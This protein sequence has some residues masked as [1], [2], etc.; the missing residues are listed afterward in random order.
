MLQC[1]DSGATRGDAG[2]YHVSYSDGASRT[3]D[4]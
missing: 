1:N 2:G 4:T 3:H